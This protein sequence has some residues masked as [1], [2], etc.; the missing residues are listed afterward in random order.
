[1]HFEGVAR[2]VCFSGLTMAGLLSIVNIMNRQTS[3]KILLG[4]ILA[5]S[6]NKEWHD[7]RAIKV[8]PG[9]AC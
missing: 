7:V 8:C 2:L 9:S 6:N 1:V 4:R 5:K 3:Q